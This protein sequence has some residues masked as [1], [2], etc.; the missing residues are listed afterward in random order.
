MPASSFH[1]IWRQ[2]TLVSWRRVVHGACESSCLQCKASHI[3]ESE[4]VHEGHLR[5]C[6]D[7]A[8]AQ[9]AMT[10]TPTARAP[11]HFVDEARH[12]ARIFHGTLHQLPLRLAA[13][14]MP[15]VVDL[16]HGRGPTLPSAGAGAAWRCLARLCPRARQDALSQG[17]SIGASALLQSNFGQVW[18]HHPRFHQGHRRSH[19][20]SAPCTSGTCRQGNLHRRLQRRQGGG[21]PGTPSSQMTPRSNLVGSST[22]SMI[23]SSKSSSGSGRQSSCSDEEQSDSLEPREVASLR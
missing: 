21:A 19:R 10:R 4:A 6:E 16:L 20:T 5:V 23:S 17:S 1:R 8:P 15:A 13:F 11:A 14:A 2:Q 9:S 3:S 7:V 18:I 22:Y 12:L